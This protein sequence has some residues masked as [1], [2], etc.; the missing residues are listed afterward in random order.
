MDDR[1]QSQSGWPLRCAVHPPIRTS[2][3]QMANQSDDKDINFEMFE[4]DAD[5]DGDDDDDNDD[6]DDDDTPKLY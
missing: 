5:V 2:A 6:D 1:S 3:P 4:I